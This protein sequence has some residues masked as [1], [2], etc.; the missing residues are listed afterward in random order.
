[1]S[2]VVSRAVNTWDNVQGP[3]TSA[4]LNETIKSLEREITS[5][6]PKGKNKVGETSTEI[7][8]KRAQIAALRGLVAEVGYDKGAFVRAIVSG[9][10]NEA[11]RLIDDSSKSFRQKMSSVPGLAEV[12]NSVPVPQITSGGAG[13]LGR[14]GGD[15]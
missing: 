2:I 13:V 9:N 6:K 5:L 15:E 1:M 10:K 14:P 4:H 7:E 12:Y 8:N 3:Q 11:M